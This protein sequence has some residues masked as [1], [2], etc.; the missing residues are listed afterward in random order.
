MVFGFGVGVG[1]VVRVLRFF[2]NKTS[3]DRTVWGGSG[4]RVQR[5]GFG[6]RFWILGFGFWVLGFG[7]GFLGF[8]FWALELESRVQRVGFR[9]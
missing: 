6:L 2:E 5:L 3:H 1:V 4:F 7:F 9:V 8:Q